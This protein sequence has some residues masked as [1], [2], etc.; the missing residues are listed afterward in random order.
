MPNSEIFKGKAVM[1]G[2]STS[3]INSFDSTGTSAFSVVENYTGDVQ[4]VLFG[5]KGN[6]MRCKLQYADS[7][8]LTTAGGI[9]ICESSNGE[10]IDVI[11]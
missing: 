10:V 2:N 1:V 4:A 3:T 8:G 11:W 9:G 5:S 7:G 6:T